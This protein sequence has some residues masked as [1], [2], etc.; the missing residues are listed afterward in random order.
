MPRMMFL[1][2]D[3]QHDESGDKSAK[4]RN[5]GRIAFPNFGDT[6]SN[7]VILLGGLSGV[8]SLVAL[9]VLDTAKGAT[10]GERSPSEEWQLNTCL[11]IF[12]LATVAVSVGSTYYHW[13]PTD[14][15]LVWDRLPMTVA[16]AAI[17]CYMLDEYLPHEDEI[18]N[19]RSMGQELL[20]PLIA[21]GVGSVLY[22]SWTDD[23]RLYAVIS[24]FPM[25]LMVALVLC[26][27]PPRHGGMVQQVVGLLLYAAAKIC[28]DNDYEIF[29]WTGKRISGHSLKHILAGLAPVAIAHMAIMRK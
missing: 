3:Y 1:P 19:E 22:W 27:S 10:A 15:T 24:I 17:F 7:I 16:F 21:L 4:T 26:C 28:E 14:A 23:L 25:F 20:F 6:A 18:P 11:P 13:N 2:P 5:D 12:F 9:E 29:H 8:I